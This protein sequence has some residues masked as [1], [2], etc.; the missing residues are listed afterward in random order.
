MERAITQL[1]YGAVGVNVWPGQLSALGSAPWGGHPSSMVTDVQSG[2][3]WVHN[4]VM[5]EEV[6]KSV[7]RQ[8]LTAPRKLPYVP[9]HRSATSLL[10][11]LTAVER[12][13]GW[14]GLPAVLDAALRS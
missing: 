10:R 4:T 6:E 13:A 7:I 14:A 5:L 3:G 2:R 11:R 12:G 9:G 8:S 1:R